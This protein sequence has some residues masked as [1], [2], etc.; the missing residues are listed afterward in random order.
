M[1]LTNITI[2]SIQGPRSYQEDSYFYTKFGIG[3][4]DGIGGHPNGDK[5]SQ[6]I[7]QMMLESDQWNFDLFL[8][9]NKKIKSY[10][11]CRGAT[12]ACAELKDNSLIITHSGDSR[13]YVYRPSEQK[14]IFQT[15]DHGEGHILYHYIGESNYMHDSKTI[16][17]LPNDMIIATTDGVH[18]YFDDF[19]TFIQDNHTEEHLAQ[20]ICK[21][22]AEITYDNAT[23]VTARIST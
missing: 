14:T 8:K 13:I 6:E 3:V 16:S 22:I 19:E 15:I 7:K 4:S 1:K 9:I 18:D 21:H 23:C 20:L 11:D 2:S 12:L 17:I 10:S 5:A